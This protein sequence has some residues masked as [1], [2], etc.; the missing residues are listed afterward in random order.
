MT[1]KTLQ[2][3]VQSQ[4]I[5]KVPLFKEL[6]PISDWIYLIECKFHDKFHGIIGNDILRKYNAIIDYKENQLVLNNKNVPLEFPNSH[7]I[8]IV[9]KVEQGLVHIKE[10]CDHSGESIIPEGVYNAQNFKVEISSKSNYQDI[11]H[12]KPET[13]WP[14][15]MEN[16]HLVDNTIPIQLDKDVPILEHIRVDHMNSEE[17]GAFSKLMGKYSKLFHDTNTNLTFTNVIKHRINT[18][19]PIPIHT[20]SYRYPYVH[21]EEVHKQ[22]QEMLNSNIIRHSNS[23][24]SAPI[25]IVPKKDDASGTKK[26]RLVID[27]RKLNEKTI[28]DKYPIPNIDEILDKLGRSMYFS[29]LDLAKGFHQ[30]EI[31]ESDVHKTAFS[32]EGG[33]Y[34]FLR[35]PFG[36]KTAPATF[37]RLMNNIL[38]DLLGKVCLVYLDDIIV[39]STSLEEH[40]N[41]LRLVFNR[42][43]EANL[44]IQIDKCEFLR[45]ETNFLGHVV[46]Q[47]GVKPNPKKVECIVNYP[48]PRTQKQI[49]QF[50]GLS[51]Y[52][53]KFIQNYSMIA[54]P[55]TRNLKKDAEI[56]I[57]DPE[58]VKSFNELKEKL[59]S[60]PL[61][62]YPDF[63]KTFVLNTDASNFALGAVLSQ[64]GHPVCYASRTLNEHEVNYSTIE[65]ELLAIVWAV[66]YFRP[67][68]FGRKFEIQT[69]H[70]P[71]Q[72]LFNIKE[73]NS[74]LVRWR[75]KLEEFDYTIKYKKGLLN[76]N[77]DALSRIVPEINLIEESD[78]GIIP[79]TSSPINMHKNQIVIEIVSSGSLKIKTLKIFNNQRKIITARNFDETT[80]VTLI[81]NHF[82][83]NGQNAVLIRDNSVY[84]IFY[85]T[86]RKNF[87]QDS[88]FKIVRCSQLL[89]DIQDENELLELIKR[90]HLRNNH[91]GINENFAQLKFSIYNPKLK[92]RIVQ[93][94]NNCEIC[95]KEKYVRKPPKI[96]YKI[97]ETPATPAEIVHIDVF[98]TLEKKMFL[99]F[100]DK[101]TKYAQAIMINFRTWSEFR[102]KLIQYISIM[103]KMKK[104]VV[105]NEL[106]FKATPIRQFL[107]H[108]NIEVH[109]T[110]N[111]NHNSNAD[112]ERLHNTI[113]EHIRLLRHSE[114]N[115]LL[116]VEEKILRIITFY[117]NSIHSTTNKKPID[118]INGK[119]HQ[120]EYRKIYEKMKARKEHIIQ[121]L[122]I[123]RVDK[124]ITDGK[125]FIKEIRGGKNHSKYRL[126]DGQELDNDH[127]L[128]RRNGLK[129]YK[130]HVKMKKRFQNNEHLQL[131]EQYNRR[132]RMS[133]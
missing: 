20:K 43:M 116:S 46:N 127:I 131:P 40:I 10:H 79:E 30:V 5:F 45:R 106:G 128:D 129:Y 31:D 81:K 110:S 17:R 86:V 50:L 41:S 124:E 66:K 6:G 23:P 80:L 111:S 120:S 88:S 118:F 74:R 24:Y 4:T 54:R 2:N 117:N 114:D 91:R 11:L 72:W 107:E 9:T 34:E 123:G 63:D 16:Y 8:K 109:Y 53:R 42:L 25:W 122:N 99:T 65:K 102:S 73:P 49:K 48:I 3:K 94:I 113:N 119:I 97:T 125:N 52:Y 93:F 47:N 64:D 115:D 96:P 84:N 1:L 82:N 44:K 78:T 105:D 21:R 7:K 62:I 61:L 36:L 39:F 19:D 22:I 126:I 77:A 95:N 68:I 15:T 33:H 103:G 89:T 59:I 133:I 55:M 104:I 37:Q 108:E 98:Y 70:Q 13:H 75:L 26:W 14:V 58:Y 18:T 87:N 112:V 76:G 121:K 71:L 12:I 101:F 69:D 130:P 57:T 67:Y 29:T 32:V 51:G 90:E 27:Y 132:R 83:P 38:G 28:D 100:I 85:E 56:K 92:E 35:M 60:E